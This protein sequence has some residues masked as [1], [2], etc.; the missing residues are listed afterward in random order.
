MFIAIFQTLLYLSC[1]VLMEKLA[2]LYPLAQKRVGIFALLA[3]LKG[4]VEK[5]HIAVR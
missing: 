1:F 2:V 4:R 5:Y 3:S